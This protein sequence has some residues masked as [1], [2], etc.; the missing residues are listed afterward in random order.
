MGVTLSSI[1]RESMV[2]F[3]HSLYSSILSIAKQC[4]FTPKF[5][6]MV[7]NKMAPAPY[8]YLTS[9][10]SP[11]TLYHRYT[12]KPT[13]DHISSIQFSTSKPDVYISLQILDNEEEVACVLGKGHAVIPAFTFLRDRDPGEDERRSGS[14]TCEL[15]CFDFFWIVSGFRF[16]ISNLEL[17]KN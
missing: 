4:W 6:L 17:T 13:E 10:I 5:L 8:L 15:N 9:M 3:M 14:R 12:L 1:Q 16:H 11:S 7:E 2:Q